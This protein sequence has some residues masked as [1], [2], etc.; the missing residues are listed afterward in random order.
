M[1]RDPAQPGLTGVA[2]NRLEA[3][4][5]NPHSTSNPSKTLSHRPLIVSGS[6]AA[7]SRWACCIEGEPPAPPDSRKAVTCS[8]IDA[9]LDP[10]PTPVRSGIGAIRR[11]FPRPVPGVGV[12]AHAMRIG[13][14]PNPA[15]TSTASR[16]PPGARPFRAAGEAL[17]RQL[18]AAYFTAAPTSGGACGKGCPH[19]GDT[20]FKVFMNHETRDMAS[21]VQRPSDVSS[22]ASETSTTG[23][24]ESRVTKHGLFSPWVREGGATGNRRPDHCARRQVTVSRFTV[25]HYC[26]PLFGKKYCL[27]PLSRAARS[28]P[29]C[30]ELPGMA[31]LRAACAGGSG[32]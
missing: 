17:S 2:G 5:R 23:F 31:R 4:L 20:A 1:R 25:V 10:L 11:E 28:L 27:E 29:A 3:P 30:P 15:R 22:G 24:H 12:F 19:D 6:G 26:S 13:A 7:S 18:A 14:A 8:T 9:R 16:K 21:K 32:G